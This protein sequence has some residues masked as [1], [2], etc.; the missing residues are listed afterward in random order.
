M[1]IQEMLLN[2]LKSVNP[3]GYKKLMALKDSGKDP[4]EALTEMY[5]NG[6]INDGQLKQVQRQAHLFGV[7]ISDAQI[8]E[9]ESQ[10]PDKN[11]CSSVSDKV[12]SIMGG[13]NLDLALVV[14]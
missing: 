5:R 11:P 2:R 8:R 3:E 7:T 10:K 13:F 9:I 1:S 14:F 6:E 4:V 12:T